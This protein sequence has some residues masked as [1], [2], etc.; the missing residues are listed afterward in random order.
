MLDKVERPS[1]RSKSCGRKPNDPARELQPPVSNAQLST[2][3]DRAQR[4]HPR[5]A[6]VPAEKVNNSGIRKTARPT[7]RV[8]TPASDQ[9]P[10]K[11]NNSEAYLPGESGT[12][13]S[14]AINIPVN[15]DGIPDPELSISEVG[16]NR[17]TEDLRMGDSHIDQIQSLQ[18]DPAKALLLVLE[19]KDIKG[20]MVKS[21]RLESTTA[22]LAEQTV[23]FIGRTSKL[24]ASVRENADKIT[25]LEEDSSTLKNKFGENVA[26]ITD[27]D[28]NLS[29]LKNKVDQHDQQLANLETLKDDFSDSANKA[30]EQMNALIDTQRNQV[31]TF[32]SGAKQLEEQWKKDV[33]AEMEKKFKKKENA[34]HCQDLKDQAFQN[35]FNLIIVGMPEDPGKSTTQVVQNFLTETLK[36]PNMN[37]KD[38]Y[39]IGQKTEGDSGYSRPVN[40]IFRI[41]AHRNKIW[42]NRVDITQENSDQKIR[43]Q[44]DLPKELREGMPMLYKAA[45]AAAKIPELANTKIRNYQLEINDDIYQ[46]TDLED[47]P[48]QIRPSTLTSP[49]SD[50]HMVFFSKHA[51]LSNHFPSQF[52]VN[53]QIFGSMEHFLAT[54]RAELSGNEDIMRKAQKIQDPIQAKHILNRL[55]NNHQEEWDSKVEDIAMEGLRAKFTQNPPLA[56]YLCNTG[57]LVL[58]EATTN[59]RWGIG[60][61]LN[62]DDV[63]D[64][65]K[66]LETGNLLGRSLM[67]LRTELQLNSSHAK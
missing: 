48:R 66:W 21:N 34:S 7:S 9:E 50:T 19:L 67:K 25:T 51:K 23:A 36:I 47:L 52:Q 17:G 63:L 27:L 45:R 64:H 6:K 40:V 54:R 53:D 37:I 24:E 57:Q 65:S 15:V 13:Q 62:N 38:A 3:Q 39:R 35:R 8:S 56:K 43:I 32:N 41:L 12:H 1:T 49:R 58:G 5:D 44:A 2:S 26:K 18:K 61:D 42:R 28:E 60:M 30:V 10:F 4:S 11:D 46:V 16:D 22:S 31:E 33:L 20:Q 29:T 55:H 59:R 14:N